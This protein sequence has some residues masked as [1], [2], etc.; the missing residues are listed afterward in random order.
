MDLTQ[1]EGVADLV[2]AESEVQARQAL[3]QLGGALGGRY[4]AWRDVLVQGLA[5]LE[6]LVDFPE[7]DVGDALAGLGASLAQLA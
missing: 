4:A 6:V 1:A 2:D 3:D 7:D 5:R